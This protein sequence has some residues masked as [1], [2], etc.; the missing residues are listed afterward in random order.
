MAATA[1]TCGPD[2][3][4]VVLEGTVAAA[5]AE[6]YLLLPFE[7]QDGTTRVEVG[8]EWADVRTPETEG[9]G[10]QTVLDLGL[11]DEDGTEG[12]EAF[13]G[14]SGSRQG[15]VGEG[16]DPVF[17]QADDAERGY[18]AGEVEPG[19]WHVELGVGFVPPAGATYEVTVECLATETGG[20]AAPDPVD[21]EHVARDEPGWYLGDL[22]LHAYHS[23][24]EGLAGQEMVDAAAAAGLD[25]IP[26]TEYVT[27]AHWTGLGQVQE[28]NP[29]VVI[30]PGR[31]VITY[32]GHAV[33]LG[34]TP[35]TVE[36]RVG[37]EGASLGAV[38]EASR[39]DGALFSIAHPT[40]FPG[41]AGEE[42]CRG[43]EFT[44]GDD[45]DW[46]AVDT[47]EVVT[48]GALLDGSF[49]PDPVDGTV[50]NPFVA[51][52]VDLWEEQLLA[53]NRIT[54]VGGSDDKEGD[55]Y[56]SA[57]T[58]VWAE[59]LS[60]DALA[61]AL[62]AGHAYVLARGTEH[63]PEV[64]VTAAAGDLEAIVGDTLVVD[65][66]GSA[67]VEVTVTG[68]DGSFVEVSRNG[69]P[70]EV[71][72]VVGDD[73]TYTFTADRVI[74]EEG[75][76]G[77]FWRVDT[78]DDASVTTVGNPIFLADAV[79]AEDERPAPSFYADERGAAEVVQPTSA[80]REA[81][82]PQ[83]VLVVL[84]VPLVVAAVAVWAAARPNRRARRFPD[85]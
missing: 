18:L 69:E 30:W 9:P 17:V 14:W 46:S 43:C 51:T 54:A 65:S 53:G 70:V 63:S 56:G 45:V 85:V 15:L 64:E 81:T 31:E 79:P 76:L 58:A 36:Y 22:H 55:Q 39:A 24:P 80:T 60:R 38:Q 57:A 75:P 71:V 29:D 28:D 42:L 3:D 47:I 52:A 2:G 78:F 4:P 40:T 20:P 12:I 68:G 37:Y 6:T 19:T 82:F 7:V 44:L 27:P 83:W 8:Y 26:V 25:F 13:R 32:A 23:N 84:A 77:T 41:E 67:E 35:S 10:N 16:Q 74:E 33:V 66:A 34:E 48:Q 61:D 73:F 72:P 49:E 59:Q 62:Q 1:P 50:E 11:W 21:P 5:D